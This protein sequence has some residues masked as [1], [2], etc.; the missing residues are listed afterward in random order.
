LTQKLKNKKKYQFSQRKLASVSHRRDAIDG[1][2]LLS[3]QKL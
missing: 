3:K 1:N 2:T